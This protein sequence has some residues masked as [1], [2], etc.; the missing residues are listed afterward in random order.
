MFP[1]MKSSPRTRSVSGTLKDEFSGSK[2]RLTSRALDHFRSAT[3]G[4]GKQRSADSQSGTRSR[5]MSS[6]NQS[7]RIENKQQPIPAA[8]QDSRENRGWDKKIREMSREKSMSREDDGKCIAGIK[9]SRQNIDEIREAFMEFDMDGDG[10]ITTK[11]LGTVM[12]RLNEFP[13]ESELKVM[14]AEVDQ[15]KN[16]TIEMDEFLVMMAKRMRDSNT[17]RGFQRIRFK[18]RRGYYSRRTQRG[19]ER[20][21]RGTQ[22]RRDR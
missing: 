1:P 12:M 16:G 13:T 21:G 4:V 18:Q 9:L 14:I 20:T 11:E 17:I 5:S 15:D 7:P 22:P 6:S 19:D 2:G 3:N 10:T 8:R